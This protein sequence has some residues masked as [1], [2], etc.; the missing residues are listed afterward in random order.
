LFTKNYQL[1]KNHFGGNMKQH[2]IFVLLILVNSLIGINNCLD[3]DGSNDHVLV[4]NNASL[5]T[6]QGTIECWVKI[7]E[8]GLPG[9]SAFVAMRSTGANS[10]DWPN[11]TRYS[12][13]IKHDLSGVGM[14][15]EQPGFTTLAYTFKKSKWYH[16]AFAVGNDETAVTI[17]GE[18]IG[19]IANALRTGITGK[20]LCIG[21]HD[22]TI[23]TTEYFRGQ[24]EDVRIWNDIRTNSE[25]RS[26]MYNELNGNEAG[27]LAYYKFNETSGTTA[28]DV[29]A[30]NFDGTCNN[31]DNSD[32]QASSA[33]FGPKNCVEFS[34]STEHIK[35]ST[36]N[37]SF[38]QGTISFWIK[39]KATPSNHARV[40]SDHWDDDEIYLV[41]G[42]GNVA[43]WHMINGDELVSSSP[44]PNNKW[45]HVAITMNNTNSKLYIN[46]V[47]DDE[48]GPSD[49]D[50][51][52]TFEIG[53][54]ST[55]GNFEVVNGYL[56]EFRI[57]SVVRTAA[58][59]QEN[60]CKTLTGNETN[61]IAYYN[62]DNTSGTTLQDFSG[63]E[64][65]G[66]L[67]NTTNDDWVTSTAFN[68]LLETNNTTLTTASN[69]SRASAPV[70][71][72]NVGI[73]DYT[74]IGTFSGDIACDNLV[75]GS[76]IT[77]ELDNTIT[78][79]GNI[80]NYG[81]LSSGT[82]A[83]S[84]SGTQ[85][86]LGTTT[87]NALTIDNGS[88]L[89]LQGNI[90][91]NGTFSNNGSLTEN[92]YSLIFAG[93]SEQDLP[94]GTIETITVDNENGAALTSGLTV[95]GTLTLTAG[96]LDLNGQDLI[97][98]ANASLAENGG[99]VF[100]S[101]SVSTTRNLSGIDTDVAGL[102]FKITEDGDLGESTITRKHTAQ[103]S[104]G[105][106][107]YFEITSANAP[108][109]AT[110]EFHY[111]E[112]ELNGVAEADLKI[113]KSSDNGNTWIEQESSVVDTDNNIITLNGVDSFSWWTAGKSGAGQTLPVELSSFDAIQTQSNF[114][115]LN[116]ITQTESDL[117]GYYIYRSNSADISESVKLNP[118]IIVAENSP[119]AT[120]YSY[121]DKTVEIGETYYFWLESMEYSGIT[122][123]FG[124][125]PL[126]ITEEDAPQADI[127]TVS[128][129]E[130][131]YPNPFNLSQIQRGNSITIN[132]GIK[133]N[134]E[135]SVEIFN[136]KGQKVQKFS[137][138]KSGYHTINWDAKDFEGKSVSSGVYFYRLKTNTRTETNKLM[139][140][141]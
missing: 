24:I 57:W 111:N 113:F 33:M 123:T 101:G 131:S 64:N 91:L 13:H 52:S 108:S 103:G 69:W 107:R 94:S 11:H 109:N 135:G 137:D 82:I 98:D 14:C 28:N 105:I 54:Y 83:I 10:G 15:G 21:F 100:G 138:F 116:W 124:P 112:S 93:S 126:S 84:S 106:N 86:S 44:L 36:M 30:N 59:I 3:F 118:E 125:V 72:D 58:E 46:G 34:G 104:Q 56:D 139:I 87:Y 26:N 48:S 45:T 7:A 23:F 122:R 97:L 121:E 40:F 120:N 129:I 65:D 70:A 43:T 6:N 133:E 38:T 110:I 119:I 31:M 27:L 73:Y 29:T 19:N 37:P 55:S 17:N 68:T 16:I 88:T 32:W 39:P 25:I 8:S 9:N 134:D 53:G 92:A 4:A 114:A 60:M 128:F 18:F 1:Y 22:D 85:Y 67:T 2:C 127:P 80:A 99:H 20:K 74:G 71:T 102:G 115:K 117:Q 79:D 140:V 90:T 62:F 75:I 61:L 12:F 5:E 76:G 136:L 130:N 51:S 41:S 77:S 42:A 95:G 66:V 50:I 49:T 132:F 89:N 63:N 141:K 96:N 78:A 47:L 35:V 81:T